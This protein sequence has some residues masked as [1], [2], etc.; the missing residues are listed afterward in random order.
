MEKAAGG[1]KEHVGAILK[2]LNLENGAPKITSPKS[3]LK[4]LKIMETAVRGQ[5]EHFGAI[6]KGANPRK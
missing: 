3:L 5:K 6:F 2:P 4:F 1:E